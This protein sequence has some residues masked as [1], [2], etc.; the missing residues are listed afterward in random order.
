MLRSGIA[1]PSPTPCGITYELCTEKAC[2][3]LAEARLPCSRSLI[4][5]YD[6]GDAAIVSA[7][8]RM[9]SST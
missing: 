2:V 4:G 9:G 6:H 5:T 8:T 3:V 1:V 7:Y